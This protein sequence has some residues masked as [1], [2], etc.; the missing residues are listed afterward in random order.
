[1]PRIL[2]HVTVA[3]DNLHNAFTDLQYWQGCYWVS[4]RKGSAHASMDGEAVVALSHDRTR[5]RE[6]AHLK[7]RGDCRDPKLL[8]LDD[9]RMAM[10]FPS[11]TRGAAQRELQHYI[12]FSRNGFDWSEPQPVLEPNRWLW[13]V[14]RH[15][16]RYY[17][18]VQNVLAKPDGGSGPTLNLD[19]AVSDDLLEWETLCRIGTDAQ[20]LC[21]SDIHWWPNGEAWIVARSATVKQT[22][23]NDYF[24]SA[25]PPYTDWQINEMSARCHAPIFLEH[26]GTLYVAGRRFPEVEGEK[27][28]PSPASL[29][30]W[31]VTRGDLELVLHVPAIGDCSYPGLIK[32]PDGRICMSYY[33]QHAYYLGALPRPAR[34]HADAPEPLAPNDIYFAEIELP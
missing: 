25:Q 18:L 8:P 21:E 12:C 32:D 3:R 33:S 29:G 20:G 30:L 11:W 24:C 7:V 2:H 1:M 19:L 14:R 15:E 28:Y 9:D 17:G 22:G 16:G 31:R 26:E 34:L 10:Y 5:F 27:T 23:G 4:Y 6:V 13:R